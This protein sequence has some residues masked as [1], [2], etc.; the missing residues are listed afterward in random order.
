MMFRA[1][2]IAL[3][4]WA[5]A[6]IALAPA[7]AEARPAS[8]WAR[9]EFADMRLISAVA[10][11]EARSDVPLGLEFRLAEGWKVYWRSAGDAGYPPQI[12]WDGSANLVATETAYPVPHRFSLFG[13]ETFGYEDTVVYPITAR[14]AEPGAPVDVRAAVNALVC[15]EIC[16]P[17]E[18]TLSLALPAGPAAPTAFTQLLEKWVSQVPRDLPGIG[19]AVTAASVSGDA[20]TPTL[21]LAIRSDEPLTALDVFPE[22]P[23][24]LSFGK[25]T[26]SQSEGGL[27]AAVS[28]PVGTRDGVQLTG[29]D[30][31]LTLV[32]GRRFVERPLTV[33]QV[34]ITPSGSA[35]DASLLV[36]LGFALIGGLILNLM[37]CV[38]PVL[39]L[40]LVSVVGYGGADR[41]VIRLGF[42]A[43][44]AGIVF[45]FMVLAGAIAALKAA[46]VAVGWGVQFQQPLFLAFMASV[47]LLFAANLRGWFEIPLPRSFA[48]LGE[49]LPAE[50]PTGPKGPA[51]HFLT[52]AFAALLATPCSAPFLGTAIGFALSRGTPEIVAVFAALGIGLALPYLVVAAAPGV[53]RA[54]P[55]PG[56]W[57]VT[58]KRVLA[59]AL[60]GTGIWLLTVLAA[61]TGQMIAIAVAGLFLAAAVV[62]ATA[63]R[64]GRAAAV[65]TGVVVVVAS[66]VLAGFG[67]RPSSEAPAGQAS[68]VTAEAVSWQAF[69]LGDIGLRVAA[70]EVILVD[71]T[72]D[73]CITCQVNKRLVLDRDPV[74]GLLADGS[75]TPVRA[76]WTNPDPVIADYLASF[77]RY[78][79]PFN[80]IYGPGAPQGIP[81]PELLTTDAV[82]AAIEQARPGEKTAR[83]DSRQKAPI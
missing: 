28:V 47:V 32:D 19:L 75:V 15:S 69:S 45:S 61:Q 80:V 43:S 35:T 51:G 76:D 70:G 38:L 30:L 55:R 34:S 40:K 4:A 46:G 52:G 11:T 1:L 16:V 50:N 22:G 56:P 33:S 13:L 20:E 65:P 18:A 57:M 12:E 54:L 48:S 24:G 23:E 71:V 66:L 21:H 42:L 53:A 27:T 5:G 68:A 25:P 78:G 72:A 44:A 59:L 17:L 10:G 77:G 29:T 49:R 67:Q 74:A 6:W 82:L 8:D 7:M 36:I 73:W 26:I 79:I 83:L 60:V 63:R 37:P 64:I 3:G 31:R 58:V 81:L 2:L 39:S 62:L 14:L 9:T 41:R